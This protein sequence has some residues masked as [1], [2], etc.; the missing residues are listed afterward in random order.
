MANLF[1]YRNDEILTGLLTAAELPSLYLNETLNSFLDDWCE[2]DAD[3]SF[4][5]FFDTGFAVWAI[6]RPKKSTG[7]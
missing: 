2:P 4:L 6:G 1:V 3:R 7:G 5:L